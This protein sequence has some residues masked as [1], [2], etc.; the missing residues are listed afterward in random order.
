LEREIFE[1]SWPSSLGELGAVLH[2][3]LLSNSVPAAKMG[4]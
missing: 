2:P 3:N 4:D 1:Q